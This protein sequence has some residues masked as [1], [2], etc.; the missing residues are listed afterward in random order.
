MS[1]L[2]KLMYRFKSISIKKK[3]KL[4]TK[5]YESW[6]ANSKIYMGDKGANK[7]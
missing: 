2:P 4:H 1:V 6:Q 3:K 7:G 5:S